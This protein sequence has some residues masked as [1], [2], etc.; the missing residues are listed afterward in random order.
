VAAL[1][2]MAAGKTVIATKVGGLAESVLDGVTG[3]LVPPKDPAAL[4][5]AIAQLVQAPAL[6]EE[7]GKQGRARVMEHFTLTQMA[8]HN[9]SFYYE[10]LYPLR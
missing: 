3:I 9:E 8:Q 5:E 6:A 1:E 10:L 7:M 4:V 2:A